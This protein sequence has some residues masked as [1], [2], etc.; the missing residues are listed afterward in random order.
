[1][2]F[3]HADYHSESRMLFYMG[4]GGGGGGLGVCRREASMHL[5]VLYSFHLKKHPAVMNII[6]P[7]RRPYLSVKINLECMV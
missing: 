5:T 1:M 4:G 6:I 3:Y 2:H 7:Q